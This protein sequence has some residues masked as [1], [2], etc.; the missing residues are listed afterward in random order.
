[1]ERHRLV[2]VVA[3][4]TTPIAALVGFGC[5]DDEPG[6]VTRVNVDPGGTFGA[7]VAVSVV[8]RG[9]VTG[10]IVGGIDCP[11]K[12]YVRYTFADATAPG[13]AAG[14]GLK[15]IPTPGTRFAGW[16]FE[17]EQLSTK[18]RG[19]DNCNPLKRAAAQPS[20]DTNAL[21]INLP[22]GETAGTPPPGQE[23]ACTGA[24]SVPVAY[25]LVATFE[26]I[27]IPDAGFDADDGGPGELVYDAPVAGATGGELGI[28][29]GRLYWKYSVGGLHGIA[30]G[31]TSSGLKTPTILVQPTSV[32]TR[33]EVDTSNVV[34]QTSAGSLG[35]FPSGSTTAY[36][37][38]TGGPASCDAVDSYSTTVYCVAGGTLYSWP[39]TGGAA[40]VVF[41]GAP[42][43]TKNFTVDSSYFYFVD[44]PGGAGAASIVR[45]YK[46]DANG[47]AGTFTPIV[48]GETNPIR[49]QI[50]ASSY[51]FWIQYDAAN[52]IGEVRASSTSGG[53]VYTAIPAQNG[54]SFMTPD[55]S[56]SSYAYGAVVP[57]P[58]LGDARIYRG[59]AF[60]GTTTTIVGGIRALTG[61]AA[62]SSYVYWTQ[63]DGR[64]YRRP[65]L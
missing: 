40:T 28:V 16:K 65:R 55:P 21:E 38:F 15:A 52:Q 44:D 11:T 46:F 18:G 59:Y 64:V 54:L 58:G 8:G 1:M 62:D 17:P 30:S 7:E 33:F 49:L 24:T 63:N 6:P 45:M 51:L 22:F 35:V 43:S 56:S 41:T 19:P 47:D 12:C 29:G 13:A 25:K 26:E 42:A 9:R 3:I 61:L 48:T 50:G 36:T 27:P 23:G 37:S 2:L 14:L 32:I 5:S 60:G 34:Y 10:S 4:A 39:Y 20:V 53:T 31:T 57:Q